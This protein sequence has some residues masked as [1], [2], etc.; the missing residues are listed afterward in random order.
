MYSLPGL[1]RLLDGMQPQ[2]RPALVRGDRH[3]GTER[4]MAA[5]EARGQDYF[6]KL[7]L[8]PKVKA[9][10]AQLASEE[11]WQEVGRGWQAAESKLQCCSWRAGRGRA[12]WWCCGGRCASASSRSG[13]RTGSCR[14]RSP[15]QW[16]RARN[17][18]YAVLVTSLEAERLTV[19]QLYRGR[20]DVEHA[21]DELKNQWGWGGFMT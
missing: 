16:K 1:E 2:E 11:G 20:A 6:F 17:Y 4:V 10:V 12:G 3:Y 19:A 18:E 5:L 21:F 13:T 8:R 7:I 14:C 15:R 9:L